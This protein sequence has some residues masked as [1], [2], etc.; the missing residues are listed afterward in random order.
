MALPRSRPATYD[1]LNKLP[2][3][4]VGEIVGGELFASPRPAAPHAAAASSITGDLN[5]PFHR[6]PGGPQGPGGW[7]ILSEPELH[8][9]G[10]VL[11]PD[12]AGWRRERLPR[13][14]DTAAFTLAP[15]WLCEVLSPST[16]RLDRLRKL[17][18]YAEAGV[19]HVWLV[20]PIARTVE[21]YQ[22]EGGR[23]VLLG[24]HGDETEPVRIP[25]FSEIAIDLSRWW[26]DEGEGSPAAGP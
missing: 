19:A 6:R 25:P 15:D 8:L 1:D 13:I 17:P 5:G 20:D 18:R 21:V 2:E 7:W 10:D 16:V 23:W 14:A 11:V 3:H 12:L 9:G 24:T 22:L 4:V 26:L